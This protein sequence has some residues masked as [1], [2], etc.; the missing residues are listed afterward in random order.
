MGAMESVSRQTLTHS[1]GSIKDWAAVPILN[2][3]R[4]I[5]SSVDVH[6]YLQI[7]TLIVQLIRVQLMRNCGQVMRI[8]GRNL[9]QEC[10]ATH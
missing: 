6:N 10:P 1:L 7:V 4:C 2:S 3:G 5:N 9:S 8:V